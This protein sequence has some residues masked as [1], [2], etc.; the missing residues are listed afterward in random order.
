MYRARR[1]EHPRQ[2]LVEVDRARQLPEDPGALVAAVLVPVD[3]GGKL[4]DHAVHAG[5]ELLHDELEARVGRAPL[6]EDEEQ[7]EQ[8]DDDRARREK[9]PDQ[10]VAH[11]RTPPLLV[12]MVPIPLLRPPQ[13]AWF[14]PT[15][16]VVAFW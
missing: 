9:R 11:P 7:E 4:P 12:F 3:G 13:I 5:G 16:T 1:F 8:G 2:D 15:L 6:A 14:R 10:G